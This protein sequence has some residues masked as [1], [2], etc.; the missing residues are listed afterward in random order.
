MLAL[1]IQMCSGRPKRVDQCFSEPMWVVCVFP[2]VYLCYDVQYVCY[3]IRVVLL[4]TFLSLLDQSEAEVT[5]Q[6]VKRICCCGLRDK[7]SR[8]GC[9]KFSFRERERQ[10]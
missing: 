2:R 9:A 10:R 1:H 8:W 3:G 6:V 4:L 7:N 5:S